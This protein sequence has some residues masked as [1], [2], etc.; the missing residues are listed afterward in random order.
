MGSGGDPECGPCAVCA[1][2]LWH[3]ITWSKLALGRRGWR[4]WRAA[5]G[6]RLAEE[7]DQDQEGVLGV[8]RCGW[9]TQWPFIP[10]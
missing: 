9:L 1:R 2:E 3:G 10:S 8:G 7:Q 4:S 6:R 5:E